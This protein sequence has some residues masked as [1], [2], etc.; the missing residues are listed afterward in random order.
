MQDEELLRM[1]VEAAV[2]LTVHACYTV[3]WFWWNGIL[4]QHHWHVH[5]FV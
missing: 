1:L 4:M 3:A 5:F 2:D